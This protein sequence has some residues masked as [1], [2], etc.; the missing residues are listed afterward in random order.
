[1][2]GTAELIILSYLERS[3]CYPFEICEVIHNEEIAI[4]SESIY[5]NFYKLQKKGYISSENTI[6]KSKRVKY[7]L[8]PKGKD[9][10]EP[11]N[12]SS[13]FHLWVDILFDSNYVINLVN[14]TQYLIKT[15]IY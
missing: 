11:Q 6:T 14:I 13:A 15:I 1:M 3:S 4:K 5:S 2:N 9:K 10:A 8:L 7:T 12:R